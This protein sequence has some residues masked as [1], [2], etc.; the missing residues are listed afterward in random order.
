MIY[1]RWDR[2]LK[3]IIRLYLLPTKLIINICVLFVK[4]LA[5]LKCNPIT[6]LIS[7]QQQS[8]YRISTRACSIFSF[9][10]ISIHLFGTNFK[11]MYVN[12]KSAFEIRSW[13]LFVTEWFCVFCFFT[14]TE[15][16]FQGDTFWNRVLTLYFKNNNFIKNFSTGWS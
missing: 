6:V 7:C 13:K 14:I 10:F 4:S 16:T 15:T 11:I 8:R 9:E 3:N 12:Q 2:S 1:R 5:A